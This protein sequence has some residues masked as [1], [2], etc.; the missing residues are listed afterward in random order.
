M[1]VYSLLMHSEL[2]NLCVGVISSSLSPSLSLSLP[3]PSL[4]P[5]LFLSSP[6]SLS[7]P[8][9][10]FL[11]LVSYLMYG[12]FGSFA[13]TYDTAFATLTKNDSALLLSTYGSEQGVSYANRWV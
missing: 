4:S 2:L 9:S 7:P 10:L 3:S 13:P 11:S 12:P 8:L 6:L 5:S 1:F